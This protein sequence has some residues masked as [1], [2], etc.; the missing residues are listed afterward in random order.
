MKSPD[1]AHTKVAVKWGPKVCKTSFASTI[2]FVGDGSSHSSMAKRCVANSHKP[3]RIRM[4]TSGGHPL[5]HIVFI[6][7]SPL[8]F[9]CESLPA[10]KQFSLV[11][12]HSPHPFPSC[13]RSFFR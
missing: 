9:P 5:F 7:I 3:I 4:A 10:D 11:R 8:M 13:A 2:R 6:H 12:S 1:V